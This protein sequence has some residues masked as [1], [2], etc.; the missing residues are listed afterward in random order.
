MGWIPREFLLEDRHHRYDYIK[1][2]NAIFTPRRHETY[3]GGAGCVFIFGIGW[4]SVADSAHRLPYF[5]VW[6]GLRA[7]QDT[8]AMKDPA[9]ASVVLPVG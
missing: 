4:K 5:W 7:G 8:V 2:Y 1:I 3:G 9:Y 6:V